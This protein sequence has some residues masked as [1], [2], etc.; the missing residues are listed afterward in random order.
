MPGDANSTNG[1]ALKGA[2]P[3]EVVQQVG[4]KVQEHSTVTDTPTAGQN[5]RDG[6]D[7]AKKLARGAMNDVKTNAEVAAHN[8][9]PEA[10]QVVNEVDKT[11]G[12]L[13]TQSLSPNHKVPSRMF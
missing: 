1:S 13:T 9:Q 4:D 7:D 5:F 6:I 10:K 8:I 11:D 2:A 3:E 12:K